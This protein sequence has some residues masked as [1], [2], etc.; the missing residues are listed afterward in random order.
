MFRRFLTCLTALA[1]L[2]AGSATTEVA[3]LTDAQQLSNLQSFDFAWSTIRDRHWDPEMNGLDWDAIRDE[4][5]PRVEEA[6][7]MSEVRDAMG[8]M[9]SRLGMSHYALIPGEVYEKLGR[10]GGQG[11]QDGTSGID[12]R[13]IEGQAL[14][15]AVADGS[16]AAEAGVR[17][18]WAITRVR[19]EPLETAIEIVAQE[20]EDRRF[21]DLALASLVMQELRGP[22]GETLELEFLDGEDRPVKLEWV[23]TEQPGR[24]VQLGYLPPLHV[25][26]ESRPLD[27]TIGYIAFNMFID[28]A[29]VMPAFNEAMES[30]MDADGIIIDVR[31]NPGGLPLMAMGMSGWLIAEKNRRLGTI[32]TREDEVKIVVFPRP[33]TY[34]GPVAVLTDGLSGSCSEIFAGGLKDLG[35]ARIFGTRT[36]GAALPS[37]IERLPNGDA[38]QYAFANYVSEG[39]EVLEGVG[40]TPHVEVEPTREELL[41]GEDPALD[42]AMAWI[43]ERKRER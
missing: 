21:R 39:G 42:A 7:T 13:V 15:T 36:T 27:E 14:V 40:V 31:G 18:G 20:F 43:R 34:S 5:R 10:P 1:V 28:P 6:A 37:A 2:P 35:R 33:T 22:V 4:L 11:A 30:F 24:K 12:V 25:W 17:T 26:I 16:P 9:L 38:L 29:H 23:L 41:R 19:G 32:Y 3:S 8:E